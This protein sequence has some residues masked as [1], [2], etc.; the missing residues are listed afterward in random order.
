MGAGVAIDAA[1]RLAGDARLASVIAEAPYRHAITPARNMLRLRAL[2]SGWN[3]RAALAMV[4]RMS[5][6]R[7]SGGSRPFDRAA[8]A[9]R[10]AV[11]LLVIHGE[12]DEI[13]PIH[14]GR[15]IAAATPR[16]RLI[17]LAGASHYGL[18]SDLGVGERLAR[19]VRDFVGSCMANS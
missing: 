6:G 13:S 19:D 10:I 4:R 15:A 7:G 2:P 3:L 9:A 5:G 1:L 17:E 16:A 8:L 11:P 18:W 14:D 12:L